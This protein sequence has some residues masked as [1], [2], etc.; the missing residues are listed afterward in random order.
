LPDE[1]QGDHAAE[2][3]GRLLESREDAA[4]FLEPADESLDDVTTPVRLSIE[5]DEASIAVLVFFR[6]DDGRN[7]QFEQELVDPVSP[8]SLVA[9]ERERPRDARAVVVE[10]P[11][12]GGRQQFVEDLRFVRLARRESKGQ[13]QSVAVAKDVD[14]CRE[15][16]ARAA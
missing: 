16:P 11:L 8:V 10:Q 1:G 9:A 6:R 13:R 2:V 12:V 15:S 5:V 4:A 3:L 7:P 14:L